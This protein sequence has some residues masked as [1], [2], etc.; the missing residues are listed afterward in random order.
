VGAW[1]DT[2]TLAM[3][4]Q[5][6]ALFWASV[7]EIVGMLLAVGGVLLAGVAV[8]LDMPW[9]SLTGQAVVE[10]VLAAVV[11]VVSGILAGGPFILFGEIMRVLL[12]QR[13][14]LARQRRLLARLTRRVDQATESQPSAAERLLQRRS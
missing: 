13:A 7:L 6:F 1:R 9:G 12:A 5:R 11:L 14:L 4:R 10:R 8:T 2:L 3:K